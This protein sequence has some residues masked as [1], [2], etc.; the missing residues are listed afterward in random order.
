MTSESIVLCVIF[1]SLMISVRGDE[2]HKKLYDFCTK[3]QIYHKGGDVAA[4]FISGS[5]TPSADCIVWCLENHQQANFWQFIY[6][7]KT[8]NNKCFCKREEEVTEKLE[9]TESSQRVEA[10]MLKPHT[11]NSSTVSDCGMSISVEVDAGFFRHVGNPSGHPLGLNPFPG[12][13]SHLSSWS[14]DSIVATT[15]T[16]KAGWCSWYCYYTFDANIW[17]WYKYDDLFYRY[18]CYCLT[19]LDDDYVIDHTETSNIIAGN[20][21]CLGSW[22]YCVDNTWWYP[23]GVVA[24]Y[25]SSSSVWCSKQCHSLSSTFTIHYWNLYNG[26][27]Y[28]KNLDNAGDAVD[29][30][31]SV[32]GSTVS[33]YSPN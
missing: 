2:D 29:Y 6:S 4:K 1:M 16:N 18:Y 26:V 10:G 23:G 9:V 8:V 22:S 32:S 21:E 12:C 3:T 25:T 17:V 7:Y 5:D 27:C 20:V 30:S 13:I 28:C 14:S 24:S 19:T 31:G 11:G 15:T 33:C